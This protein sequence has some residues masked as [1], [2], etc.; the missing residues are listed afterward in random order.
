[1]R[2]DQA[3]IKG[4]RGKTLDQVKALQEGL[5]KKI[6]ELQAAKA[7]LPYKSAAEVDAAIA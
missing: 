3:R 1:M 6:K 7:K 4:G 2:G 5:S